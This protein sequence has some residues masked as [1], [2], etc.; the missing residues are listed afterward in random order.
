AITITPARV[1]GN[2]FGDQEIEFK[3][4]I[5]AAKAVEG[6]VV[7]RLAAGTAT[8]KAGEADLVANPSRPSYITIKLPMPPVKNGAILHTRL[9]VASVEAGQKKSAASF[10]HDLWIF[11]RDP[12]SDRVEWLKK[13]KITLYDPKG[14]TAKV[15]TAANI[16]FEEARD[17][18]ALV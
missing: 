16:P 3:F 15:F 10:E 13:L 8:I 7:W 17:V 5:D 4:R 12:F 9:A 18:D 14:N 1:W 11:P 6:K 2:V